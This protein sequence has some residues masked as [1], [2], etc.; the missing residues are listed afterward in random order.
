[1]VDI[2]L[3]CVE[4]TPDAIVCFSVPEVVI[5]VCVIGVHSL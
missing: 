1:M 3:R 5:A 4:D 2:T